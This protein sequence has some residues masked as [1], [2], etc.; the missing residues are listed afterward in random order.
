MTSCASTFLRSGRSRHAHPDARVRAAAARH[1]CDGGGARRDR[2]DAACARARR[3][4]R[5]V[6]AYV[7]FSDLAIGFA[8]LAFLSFVDTLPTSGSLSPAKAVGLLVAR[9]VA[10]P[11][12]HRL[13]EQRARLLR[14]PLTPDVD[15]G[16]F[17][18]LGDAVAA[19]GAEHECRHGGADALRAEHPAD[20][21]R[22]HGGAHAARPDDRARGDHPRRDD[23]RR[24]RGAATAGPG[25]RR[26]KRARD[27]DDRR[28]QR[29]RLGAAGGARARRRLRVRAHDACRRCGWPRRWPFRCAPRASS[30]ASRAAAS[31]RSAR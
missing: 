1:P 21:D 7:A 20:P 13:E 17:L 27:G 30:S 22:L 16:R 2:R 23:R 6:L 19:V 9:R 28:S 10:G 31:S 14:R 5:L 3:R 4:G 25:N 11:L 26:G 15:A 12:Q 8:V 24:V 29:T 18:R